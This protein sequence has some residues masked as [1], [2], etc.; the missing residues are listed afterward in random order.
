MEAS[1]TDSSALVALLNWNDAYHHWA[2]EQFD[3][4]PCPV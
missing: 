2:Q 1:L 3:H 4:V